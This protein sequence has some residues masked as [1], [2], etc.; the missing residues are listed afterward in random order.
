M[1]HVTMVT[2]LFIV[3]EKENKKQ[4]KKKNVSV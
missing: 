2:Y 3:Q 4:K 1:H